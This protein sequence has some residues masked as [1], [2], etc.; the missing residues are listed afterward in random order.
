MEAAKAHGLRV[1]VLSNFDLANIEATLEAVDLADLVDVACAAPVI[2]AEKPARAAYEI[3]ARKLGVPPTACLFFD[4]VPAYVA[5]ARVAGLRAYHVDRER[6]TSR[7]GR[8]RC[9]RFIRH[10]HTASILP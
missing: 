2:G 8:R 5:G 10:H 3:T 6:K 1:G 4:D 7:P 9:A